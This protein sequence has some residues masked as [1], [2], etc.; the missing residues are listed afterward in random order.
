MRYLIQIDE[1]AC[2]AHGD[3]VELAPELFGVD[4]VARV[5]GDGPGELVLAAAQSCPS[6]AIRL[7]DARSGAQVYP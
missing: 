7:L 5:I 6:T 2:S 1:A 4:D 3:C